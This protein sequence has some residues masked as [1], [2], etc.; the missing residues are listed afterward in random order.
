MIFRDFVKS[1][2]NVILLGGTFSFSSK[3]RT[4]DGETVPCRRDNFTGCFFSR[5]LNIVSVF[6]EVFPAVRD[7][8]EMSCKDL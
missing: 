6:F 2:G 7:F 8:E 5:L 1:E 4:P 3:R